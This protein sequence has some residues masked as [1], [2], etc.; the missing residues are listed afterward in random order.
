[1]E[2]PPE[3]IYLREQ[4]E[5]CRR[6]VYSIDDRRAK[7]AITELIADYER[8]AATLDAESVVE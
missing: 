6:L 7:E 4:I 1:M 5:R 3:A 8:Q 2:K